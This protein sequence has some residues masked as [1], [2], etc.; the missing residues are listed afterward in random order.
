MQDEIRSKKNC[1]WH[2]GYS[3]IKWGIWFFIIGVF[4]GF[5]VMIHY[6]LGSAYDN[7]QAFLS[8]ITLWFGSPLMFSSGFLQIGGLGMAIIGTLC[9]LI[10]KYRDRDLTTATTRSANS[11]TT[12]YPEH[13]CAS[14]SL[15]NIGLIALIL[16]GYIGYYVIDYFWPGFYYTPINAGKN[17]WLI[18][19]GLSVLIYIIGIIIETGC[20]MKCKD[21]ICH[22]TSHRGDRV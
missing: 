1:G 22:D 9:L 17:L 8:N 18:L 12:Y 14:L 13:K 11:T 5:G 6:L 15:C 2:N 19:Q 21:G 10:G 7:T 3:F 4:L 16:T 20:I